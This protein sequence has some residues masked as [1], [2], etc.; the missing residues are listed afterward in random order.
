MSHVSQS[1]W[2][3]C[4]F[5][6]VSQRNCHVSIFEW[7][8]SFHWS[9]FWGVLIFSEPRVAKP[10]VG[11]LCQSHFP[12]EPP[13]VNFWMV[14]V[15][16]LTLFLGPI[17]SALPSLPF[18]FLSFSFLPSRPRVSSSSPPS[19]TGT[20]SFFLGFHLNLSS[21]QPCLRLVV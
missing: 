4:C 6:L 8:A 19:S 7:R 2:L 16:S 10:L 14:R 5:D 18:I 15:I 1:R 9:C 20:S 3:A 13:R 21:F 17:N 12:K 11:L